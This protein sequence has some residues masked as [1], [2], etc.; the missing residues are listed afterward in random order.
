MRRREIFIELTSLLDVIMIMLFV[1][2]TQARTQTA[3]ALASAEADRRAA[4]AARQ[5][6]TR[7]EREADALT[8]QRD[9]ARDEAAA[10][11]RQLLSEDLVLENSLVVTLSVDERASIRLETEGNTQTV[12]YRWEDDNYARN[13]LRAALRTAVAGEKPVFLVW[14]Y[15]RATIYRAEYNMIRDLLQELKLEA[16]QRELAL[17]ILELDAG[18]K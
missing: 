3:D 15:D 2:L 7:L 8:A 4:E 14:Q 10:W 16:R 9:A 5:E 12:T 17:S 6:I 13:A 11:Q 1:L 18:N